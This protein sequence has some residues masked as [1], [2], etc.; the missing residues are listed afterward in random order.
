MLFSE[1]SKRAVRAAS[2]LLMTI[3]VAACAT[4]NDPG[5]VAVTPSLPDLSPELVQVCKDPG[6]DPDAIVALTENRVALAACRRLHQDTV[7]FYLDAKRG[8]EGSSDDRTQ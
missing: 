7:Q 6:V 3:L 2:A 8:L 5:R 1:N 4:S